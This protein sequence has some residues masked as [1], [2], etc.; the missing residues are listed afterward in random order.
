M[1]LESQLLQKLQAGVHVH[2][3]Q[4]INMIIYLMDI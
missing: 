4:I 2:I 1:Q 3:I